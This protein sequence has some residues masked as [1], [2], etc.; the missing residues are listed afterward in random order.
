[1]AGCP[2]AD[3]SIPSLHLFRSGASTL[4]SSMA[5]VQRGV[6]SLCSHRGGHAPSVMLF[7]GQKAMNGGRYFLPNT[8]DWRMFEEAKIRASSQDR[9]M[10][11]YTLLPA[12][13][14]N[15]PNMRTA[16]KRHPKF[17]GP[18]L[19]PIPRQ[20]RRRRKPP[21]RAPWRWPA[22]ASAPAGMQP[23]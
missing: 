10:A 17:G 11:P 20:A 8:Y 19:E 2:C 13:C 1:M 3:L 23:P 18:R 6:S 16:K 4:C 9:C 14:Q 15:G 12:I 7:A 5:L 21:Q 22:P